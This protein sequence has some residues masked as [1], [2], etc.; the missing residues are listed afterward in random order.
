VVVAAR[1][2]EALDALVA[3]VTRLRG[4]AIAVATDVAQYPVRSVSSNDAHLLV[5]GIVPGAK[6]HQVVQRLM[7]PDMFGGWR[8]RALSVDDHPDYNP[9]SYRRGSVWP[10]EQATAA[11]GFARYGCWTQLR[12]LAEG[13][14]AAAALFAEHGCRRRSTGYRVIRSTGTR[15]STR[16][17]ARRRPGPRA[18]SARSSRLCSP[19]GR[20]PP[21]ACS[22]RPAPGSRT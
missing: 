20:S 3:E 19:C 7:A 12:T 16:S 5:A 10:V 6:A 9:F 13:V 22:C 17:R 15:L 11:L 8:I 1:N 14:F 4:R 18:A 2:Q 21:P